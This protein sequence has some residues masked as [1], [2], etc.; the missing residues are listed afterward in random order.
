MEP[1]AQ[2]LQNHLDGSMSFSSPCSL[3][4]HNTWPRALALASLAVEF[5]LSFYFGVIFAR[6]W[7][8]NHRQMRAELFLQWKVL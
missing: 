5:G 2:L 4:D 3:E 7:R 1:G 8:K 6:P